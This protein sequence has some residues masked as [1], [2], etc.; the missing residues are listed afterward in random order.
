MYILKQKQC[1]CHSKTAL[2]QDCKPFPS[3]NIIISVKGIKLGKAKL[4]ISM[5]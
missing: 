5:R 3:T 1:I 2:R 4:E